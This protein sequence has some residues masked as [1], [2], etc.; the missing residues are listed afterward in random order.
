MKYKHI[1]VALDLAEES[2]PSD[3][4]VSKAVS[5]A[6]NLDAKLSFVHVDTS[7]LDYDILAYDKAEARLIDEKQEGLLAELKAL[8]E[9]IE[10]PISNTL[11][12]E[13]EVEVKLIEA[14]KKMEI[15]L[16]ICGHHHGFWSRW[17]SSTH[18]LLD[19]TV[20]DLLLVRI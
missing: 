13:G 20:I 19:L 10:Y 17:W 18:K 8:C 15:D 2:A 3:L 5:L 9:P 11:V 16:L 14:V 4:V 12:L 7:H 6:K 1:L